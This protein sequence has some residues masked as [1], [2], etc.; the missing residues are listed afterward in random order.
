MAHTRNVFLKLVVPVVALGLLSA[1]AA[2]A[3]E[4]D[5]LPAS[6]AALEKELVA[7]H[8]EA[9]RRRVQQ[10]LDQVADFWRRR[11]AGI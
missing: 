4:L 2:L 5:W 1:Q 9:Q 7:E 8:G 10:G 11:T 6:K 3:G